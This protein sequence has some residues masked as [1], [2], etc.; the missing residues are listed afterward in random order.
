M[1]TSYPQTFKVC[2]YTRLETMFHGLAR[3]LLIGLVAAD[4][5]GAYKNRE[6][7]LQFQRTLASL[8]VQVLIPRATKRPA[9]GTTSLPGSKV[10]PASGPFLTGGLFGRVLERLLIYGNSTGPRCVPEKGR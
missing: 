5:A 8:L 2:A 3:T 6:L 9:P 4:Y 10:D 7:T 1:R